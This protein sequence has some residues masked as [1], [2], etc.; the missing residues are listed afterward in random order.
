MK[1]KFYNVGTFMYFCSQKRTT[2][3]ILSAA[4]AGLAGVTGSALNAA[5]QSSANSS[6]MQLTKETMDEQKKL[7]YA[8]NKFNHSEAA[9]S[10]QFNH[11][12]SQLARQFESDQNSLQFQRMTD[13]YN[14]NMSAQAQVKQY[15]SA[16]LNPATLGGTSFSGSMPSF[17]TAAGNAASSSPVSS[18]GVP[19]LPIAKV[20]PVN[21]GDFAKVLGDAVSIGTSAIGGNEDI[22]HKITENKY[23]D[24]LQAA[25]VTVKQ[26]EARVLWNQYNAITQNMEQTRASTDKIVKE[27]GLVEKQGEWYDKQGNMIDAQRLGYEI[28]N[29]FKGEHWRA[30]ID[31]L[32]AQTGMQEMEKK[33]Y[34][35]FMQ[36]EIAKNYG[37]AAYS[38]SLSALTAVEK[39]L[40]EKGMQYELDILK[41]FRNMYEN[42]ND[43]LSVEKGI[44]KITAGKAADETLKALE[45]QNSIWKRGGDF[46][47]QLMGTVA[48]TGMLF[49]AAKGARGASRVKING[50]YST[51]GNFFSDN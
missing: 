14:N 44:K 34:T 24:A 5:S 17:A 49:F 39:E 20:N 13:W 3:L 38:N 32:A 8:A 7:F 16:G 35:A 48:T 28:D 1:K 9:L 46:L 6:N 15:L 31:N 36:S 25:G 33:W 43:I 2:G 23:F 4:I 50:N 21:Y 37:A 27:I 30:I 26:Q 41:E 18:S 19:S 29:V 12:E 47:S 40:K 11:E 10:R 51:S 45:Y 22:K 42:Q